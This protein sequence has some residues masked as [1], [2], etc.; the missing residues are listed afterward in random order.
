M[1]PSKPEPVKPP[2]VPLSLVKS[3]REVRLLEVRAGRGLAQR[4]AEM[5]FVPG[6]QVRVVSNDSAGPV[7]VLVKGSRLML[8]RGMA[9]KIWVE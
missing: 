2:P 5:G 3:G 4:L 7:V 8:G 1:N 9:Q 6:V